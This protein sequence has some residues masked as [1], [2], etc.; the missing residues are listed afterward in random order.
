MNPM[1]IG[2]EPGSTAP[3]VALTVSDVALPAIDF[4][5]FYH[6][7]RARVARALSLTLGD[8]DLAV[9]ATDEAF[10]RAYQRWGRVSGLDNPGG[11]TYRVGL[12]WATSV[13]RRRGRAPAPPPTPAAMD[14]ET[15]TEPDVMRALSE[16]EIRQRAVVVCRYLLG[17]TVAETAAALHTPAGTVKSRLHRANQRLAVRLKH[18]RPTSEEQ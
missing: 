6:D 16:L 11:W 3:V 18:L 9:E 17:W 13:L 4:A 14:T 1:V 12:N 15:V 2:V 7:N 5:D 10:V 8:V